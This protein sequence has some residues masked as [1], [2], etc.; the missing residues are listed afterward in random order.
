M[1]LIGADAET[2]FSQVCT[3]IS[4]HFILHNLMVNFYGNVILFV[5]WF[6]YDHTCSVNVEFIDRTMGVSPSEQREASP[7]MKDSYLITSVNAEII[8]A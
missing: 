8:I 1:W 7:C 6:A 5:K 3:R 2:F 4:I